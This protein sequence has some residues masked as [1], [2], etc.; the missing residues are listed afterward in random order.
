[1]KIFVINLTRR[2]DRLNQISQDLQNHG[3]SFERVDAIDA[4]SDPL[5]KKFRRPFLKLL[6]GKRSHGD[7]PLANYL[8]FRKIWQ[9][10]V[11]ENIHQALILEDDTKI[12]NWD[13]RFLDLDITQHGL[14]ILRLGAVN[15]SSTP[16][17]LVSTQPAKTILGRELFTGQVWG[18]CA[19]IVTLT[20][21]KKFLHHKKYWFP[22]DDYMRFE[23][24][25][26][27]N[28]VII[29]P[30]LWSTTGSASDVELV[31]KKHNLAQVL[32]LKVIK[33]LRKWLFFPVIHTYLRFKTSQR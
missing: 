9:K 20:A 30:L 29:S 33:P 13:D 26:G 4:K 28:H 23:K 19:T 6:L 7:G 24:C 16:E 12:V 8:S 14:D 17:K 3:L 2:R 15:N 31:K 25:F 11:H 22:S 21:A 18:N 1:M 32:S 27:I 10:M 5:I